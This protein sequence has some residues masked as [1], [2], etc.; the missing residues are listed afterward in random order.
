MVSKLIVIAKE[1]AQRQSLRTWL[2][3]GVAVAAGAYLV[4]FVVPRP[5]QF[6]YASE[7][8]CISWPTFLP[9]LHA[10]VNRSRFVVSAEGGA[11]IGGLTI[12]STRT[13]VAPTSAPTEG[14]VTVALSP[15][16]GWLFRQHLAV[17]VSTLP[18]LG[19]HAI[20]QSAVP[21][22]KPLTLQLQ[23][24]DAIHTYAIRVD[25]KDAPCTAKSNYTNLECDL[26]SLQL[27]QGREYD[28]R[29]VRGFGAGKKQSITS[30][31][32]K[33]LT[34]TAITGGSVK[35]GETVYARPA[36][37]T[38]TADK[39]LKE[40]KVGIVSGD[41]QAAATV[42]TTISGATITAKLDK[43]LEREKTYTLTIDGVEATDGS[44]LAE[45]YKMAFT[46]SGGPKVTGVSIGRAGIATDATIV[47]S[48]D[49]ELSDKQDITGIV[50]FAGG[51]AQIT[52]RGSQV[53]Y[54]LQALGLCT[55]FTLSVGKGLLS[56][57]DISSQSEWSYASRT[58]CR[59]T[60]VY[61]TSV[62]GRALVAYTFGS[63]GPVTMYVG[64]IHG[65]ES[66]SSGLMKA[67]MDNLEATPSLYSNRRIVVVPTINPDGLAAGSRTNSRGVNLNRNFPTDGWVKDINDTDGPHEGGG[68]SEPLSEPEASALANLTISL[69]PRLLLSFHA[70]GS[71]VVG[72][73]GGYSAGYA[74][75]Y[76]SMV[77][78]RDATGQGDTFD[79]DIT[80]AYED[81]T[82]SKQGIPSM[83]IELGSYGYYNFAH[84]RAAL[85]S[86]LE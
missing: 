9:A 31:T 58:I 84:H 26:P 4:L 34:A 59:A 77:G 78:Y 38:F 61:G 13:C 55:P 66:S 49:Q 8:T 69:R 46:M 33:T 37:L 68:G 10:T 45:P 63:S 19:V 41:G 51:A 54:K 25:G 32:I 40:A 60:S 86:M 24:A 56:K 42:V 7:K 5:V 17:T 21:T 22:T 2:G 71:L 1:W 64:A 72:D 75:K 3:I 23:S 15:L 79:Y 73:P 80:G 30:A 48:F 44:S 74:A 39:A 67:W 43:E 12:I 65:N 36:E 14:S 29:V 18:K 20:P 57:Y 52:R 70:V 6:S 50:T 28:I 76:A 27:A 35:D 62:Q 85:Q 53:I 81:W 11:K 16:G 83:V 47:V 82:C